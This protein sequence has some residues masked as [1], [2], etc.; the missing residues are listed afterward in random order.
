MGKRE[1]VL[2]LAFVAAGAIL[3]RFTAPPAPAG[4]SSSFGGVFG[5]ISRAIRGRPVHA[6]VDSTRSDPVDA[7]VTELRVKVP[8]VDLTVVGEDRADVATTMTVDSDGVDEAEAQRLAKA[9]TLK[10]DRAGAGLSFGI[11]FP[12][13]GAQRAAL[14]IRVPRRFVVRVE[15]KRGKLDV[16]HVA[17]VDA[18]GNR[19]DSR[20]SDVDGEVALTH[21]GAS[22]HISGAGS[23]RLTATGTNADVSGIRGSASIEISGSEIDLSDIHGPADVRSRN[24]DIRL[25]DAGALRPPLRLDVQS[26]RLDLN[27][28]QTETRI[29]GRDTEI[30]VTMARAVPLTVSNSNDTLTLLPPLRDGFTLDAVATD[31]SLRIDDG[32]APGIDVAKTADDH[33]QR[34]AG[35]VRGGGPVITLRNTDGDI[36]IRK[37]DETDQPKTTA[38]AKPPEGK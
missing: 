3:Y 27:Q 15:E 24:S 11:D 5:H 35:A 32:G 17:G 21:R 22:L 19:G 34:A 37:P 23:L 30:R 10:V 2:V 6:S 26:G 20:V 36:T 28:L 8:S 1:L 9:T 4:P 29:D 12:E 7:S 16:Q 13:D 33:E 25:R 18:K 14:A 38:G 31:A